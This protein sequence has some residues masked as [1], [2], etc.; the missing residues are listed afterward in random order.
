MPPSHLAR[1]A[2]QVRAAYLDALHASEQPVRLRIVVAA[3]NPAA[4]WG[5]GQPG[6]RG[7]GPDV[8]RG[9][10]ARRDFE[11]GA[12]LNPLL[13]RTRPVLAAMYAAANPC[14]PHDTR[15]GTH[16]PGSPRLLVNPPLPHPASP[17]PAATR[18]RARC[19]GS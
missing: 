7:T 18:S 12:L 3:A 4:H 19:C 2:A 11:S 16:A 6:G 15:M 10:L 9:T 8:A 13:K 5:K 1:R 17:P 14:P